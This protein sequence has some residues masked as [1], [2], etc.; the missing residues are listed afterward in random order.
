MG[1]TSTR[2]R[3]VCEVPV[4]CVEQSHRRVA[5]STGKKWT[6]EHAPVTSATAQGFMKKSLEIARANTTEDVSSAIQML[7]DLVREYEEHR[8]KKYDNDL[9]LQRLYDILPKP[10][11]EQVVLEDRCSTGRADMDLGTMENDGDREDNG[12]RR[13]T[14]LVRR[15]DG[16]ERRKEVSRKGAVQWMLLPV[17]IVGTHDKEL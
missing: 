12:W 4:H 16:T 13:R 17:W 14:G 1:W 3:E 15:L 6:T 2:S 5:A 7:E 8:D 11:E 9:K 10:T